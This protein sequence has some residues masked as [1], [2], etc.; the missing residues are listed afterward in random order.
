M[1]LKQRP[2]LLGDITLVTRKMWSVVLLNLKE[3][4]TNVLKY[5]SANEVSVSLDIYTR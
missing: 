3:A 4:L 1:E 2:K 5:S